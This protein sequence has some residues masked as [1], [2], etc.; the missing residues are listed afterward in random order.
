MT[1]HRFDVRMYPV[2]NDL[3]L[4][5]ELVELDEEILSNVVDRSSA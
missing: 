3:H 1:R 5:E 4:D 2:V